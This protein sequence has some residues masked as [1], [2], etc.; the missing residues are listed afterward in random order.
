MSEVERGARLLDAIK[1]EWAKC[2]SYAFGQACLTDPRGHVLSAVFGTIERGMQTI[3]A[4]LAEFETPYRTDAQ[5]LDDYG[6]AAEW[7]RGVA[8]D[9]WWYEIRKRLPPSPGLTDATGAVT[10]AAETAT[11]QANKEASPPPSSTAGSVATASAAEQAM[12]LI[13]ETP[14]LQ[15]TNE[16]DPCG[17]AHCPYCGESWQTRKSEAHELARLH[18]LV[19]RLHPMRKLESYARRLKREL[20]VVVNATGFHSLNVSD[21][22]NERIA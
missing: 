11:A 9:S 14:Q 2:I 18:D 19:C 4:Y 6:F 16:H 1:P 12:P 15:F 10:V 22:I 5:L 13:G 8:L 20:Q 3:K 21:L 7:Q 17:K